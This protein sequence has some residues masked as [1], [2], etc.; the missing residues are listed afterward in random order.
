[1]GLLSLG[2]VAQVVVAI[3]AEGDVD[4]ATLGKMPDVAQVTLQGAS[5]LYAQHDA[6]LPVPLIDPEVIGSARY[7]NTW[8]AVHDLL[9][10]IEDGIGVC[11]RSGGRRR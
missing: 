3:V 4:H 10:G 5:V 1:M 8:T 7:G 11:K 9:N 6:L 2:R